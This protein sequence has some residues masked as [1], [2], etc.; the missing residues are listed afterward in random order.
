MP[1]NGAS[2]APGGVVYSGGASAFSRDSAEDRQ[3]LVAFMLHCA[4]LCTPLLPPPLSARATE[5][6]GREFAAQAAAERAAGLPVT[7]MLADDRAS[8]A[9]L[10]LGF[11]AC[12]AAHI[13]FAPSAA[14]VAYSY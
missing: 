6:L 10:E 14:T 9:K 5:A 8:K 12:P 3:L 4:D 2:P 13:A 1:S 11:S 7:V